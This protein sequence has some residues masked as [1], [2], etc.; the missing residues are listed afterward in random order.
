M[1]EIKRQVE[2][3]LFAAGDRIEIN[4]IAKLCKENPNNIKKALNELKKYYK[5]NASGLMVVDEG[6][7]WKLTVREPYIQ[8]V[9]QINPHT[10]LDKT[11]IE[12]LAV[13]AWKSPILQSDVIKTRTNKAYDHIKELVDSGFLIKQKHGRSYMLK[14]SKK[15]FDY[16]DLKDKENIKER[17]KEFAD[18]NEEELK[19]TEQEKLEK[20]KLEQEQQK[21]KEEISKESQQKLDIDQEK[22]A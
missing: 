7:F 12:T 8:L 17:F 14:L 22:Q 20:E 18:I 15:F 5:D 1:D 13:I 10:E 3:V 9:Q 19:K 21:D 11:T 2:A 6:N 16:F 4:E